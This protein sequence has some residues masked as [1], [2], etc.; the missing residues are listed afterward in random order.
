[1]KNSY[2]SVKNIH[3]I[4]IGGSGMS[5][6]ARILKAMGKNVTGS[7]ANPGHTIDK[8]RKEGIKIVVGHNETNM[9]AATEMVVYSP[10]VPLNNPERS[11]AEKLT[12]PTYSYPEAVGLL[13]K[14]K[15]TICICGTHGKT[16]TTAMTA[17]VFLQNKRDPSV[18]V[19]ATI[20]ELGGKNARF[21]KDDELIIES[22]EYRRGFL[23]Y[24]P[25]VIIIT[26]LEAD[27]LDYYK[28]LAD[29]KKAFVQFVNKLPKG[30]MVVANNDDKNIRDILQNVRGVKIVW[31]GK[32]ASN[33]YHLKKSTVYL[34][35]KRITEHHLRIPGDHNLMNATA[36]IAL[37]K[38]YGLAIEKSTDGL[39]KYNGSSRRFET[40]GFMGK[41][42]VIDDY[43]HH[44][45]E[46]RATLKAAREKFGKKAK[47][48]CVFQPHQFSRTYK[49]LKGFMS[50]FHEADEVII[51]NI[52]GVRDTAEDMKKI[53]MKKFITALRKEHPNVSDGNGI[54]STGRFIKKNYKKYDVV[55][56]MGA[57]DVYKIS[58]DLIKKAPKKN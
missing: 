45:T 33:G 19:G 14:E 9:P 58:E 56:T 51:P 42:I 24:S 15:T 28:N 38:E 23:N 4:G 55:I 3:L 1:M 53:S 5:G 10:A 6:L 7:D 11:R 37:A 34:K 13:T 36:V 26:N 30:G 29:Y 44:P 46:I 25:S 12:I 50:S 20:H 8:L 48:L 41:T 17:A 18:I 35:G 2:N 27:H 52:Y 22:C 39:K 21:G 32:T 43:G 31:Y 57:G 49:L 40:I 16:T 54:A 47:I